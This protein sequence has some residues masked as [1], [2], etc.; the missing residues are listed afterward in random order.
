MQA[1]GLDIRAEGINLMAQGPR[2]I[3]GRFR[4]PSIT[5]RLRNFDHIFIR[6]PVQEQLVGRVVGRDV[7]LIP[8]VSFGAFH[9]DI[10]Y[11]KRGDA[12]VHGPLAEYH[13]LITF[14]AAQR[15]LSTDETIAL[16]SASF[17]EQAGYRELWDRD[18]DRMLRKFAEVG[19]PIDDVFDGWLQ[20]GPFMHTFNHPKVR[21]LAGIA[22]AALR[23]AGMPLAGEATDVADELA[24]S[25]SVSVYPGLSEPLGVTGS[26]E[27]K[28]EDAAE[29]W[30]LGE[31]VSRSLDAFR[32]TDLKTIAPHPQFRE[33]TR[34]VSALID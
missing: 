5:D 2:G 12:F 17:F 25:V 20:Q 10:G 27:F 3:V 24:R 23:S 9:P 11:L 15:G 18:R 1:A 16:F 29:A 22:T 7:T 31:F 32:L 6:P 28:P 19:V 21:V 33:R 30:D 14:A 8:P 26:F 4:N 34:A 13:S